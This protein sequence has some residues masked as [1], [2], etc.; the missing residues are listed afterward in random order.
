MENFTAVLITAL[1][2]ILALR[3]VLIPMRLICRLLIHGGCGL[4]CLWLLNSVSGF[5]GIILPINAVTVLTAGFLG[6]PG[7]AVTAMLQMVP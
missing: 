3:L 6:V 2:G 5:T 7:I 4:L 1:L